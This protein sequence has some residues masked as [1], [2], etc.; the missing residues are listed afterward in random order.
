[1]K[2]FQKICGR[3]LDGKILEIF[4]SLPIRIFKATVCIY[5]CSIFSSVVTAKATFSHSSFTARYNGYVDVK[6]FYR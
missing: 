2:H 6:N 3:K 1:M 4:Q 5:I